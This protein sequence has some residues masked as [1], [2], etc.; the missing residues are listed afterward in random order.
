MF[1]SS[2]FQHSFART[3]G[4]RTSRQRFELPSRPWHGVR[5]ATP[6]A[7]LLLLPRF[8][9]APTLERCIDHCLI[10]GSSQR[11]VFRA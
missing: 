4:I 1:P 10:L 5:L 9:D 2:Q 7:T 3:A 11:A 8:V 6:A